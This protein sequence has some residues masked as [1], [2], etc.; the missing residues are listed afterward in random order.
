[1]HAL[2]VI[3][4]SQLT[5][6]VASLLAR[7]TDPGSAGDVMITQ[8][9]DKSRQVAPG[10]LFVAYPG[11]NV[12]GA[13]FIPDALARGALAV[14]S[15]SPISSSLIS[16]YPNVAFLQVTNGRAALA[17]LAAAWYRYPT[18]NLRVIGVTGTDGKTTTSTLIENILLAA[19]HTAGTI[20]TVAAHIGGKEV[21]TGFHTTTPDAPDIQRYLAQMVE[22]G[23]EY[24]VV[25]ATSHGLAQHRLDAVDFDIAV[26]TNLTH[27]HLDLHG[28]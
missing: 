1:M 3:P 8:V 24:A 14:V 12:D 11:V 27:E 10:A 4:L 15:Q 5:R 22:R 17:Q 26:V 9:T 28:S 23:T 7:G 16:Q 20:T 6:A 25:E 18:R 2:M 13:Q 19:G 21:D